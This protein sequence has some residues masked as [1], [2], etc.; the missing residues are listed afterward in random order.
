MTVTP[1]AKYT[2]VSV[3]SHIGNKANSTHT[4]TDLQSFVHDIIL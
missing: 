2:L 1:K 3:L 4:G